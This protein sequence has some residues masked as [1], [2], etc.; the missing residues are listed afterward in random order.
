MRRNSRWLAGVALVTVAS[1]CAAQEPAHPA[2][3]PGP[4]AAAV[5]PAEALSARPPYP[6]PLAAVVDPRTGAWRQ[7]YVP[8]GACLDAG[9]AVLVGGP[10]PHCGDK[11]R[12]P[13]H[14]RLRGALFGRHGQHC[15]GAPD[16]L[17]APGE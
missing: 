11:L 17:P 5:P 9:P 2:V 13:F 7:V 10:C 3:L 4:P 1:A 12:H 16:Q 6:P 8:P 15:E 14:G